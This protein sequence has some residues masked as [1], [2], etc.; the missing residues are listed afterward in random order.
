MADLLGGHG[1]EPA[2]AHAAGG[3]QSIAGA[4]DDQLADELRHRGEDVEDQPP[5][6]GGGV[7]GLAQA[8]E[9]DTLPAQR[10]DDLDQVGQDRDSRSRLGMTRV[11][12]GRR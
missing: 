1:R 5:A 10:G 2:E 12:P 4:L 3:I 11:S 7:Q 8:L 6:G 9:A